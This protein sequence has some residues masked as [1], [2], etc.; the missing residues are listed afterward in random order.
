MES[1]FYTEAN[2]AQEQGRDAKV[3]GGQDD[4]AKAASDSIDQIKTLAGQATTL[5]KS[6]GGDVASIRS[7]LEAIDEQRQE[8]MRGFLRQAKSVRGW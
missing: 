5:Y 4:L 3:E 1:L 6:A 7:E 8:V 2:R